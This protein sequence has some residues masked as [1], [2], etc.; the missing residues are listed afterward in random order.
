MYG[1]GPTIVDVQ[2]SA[3][4]ADRDV[5]RMVSGRPDWDPP[6]SL[7][8]GLHEAAE[9]DA[10]SF[11]YAP[12]R[13]LDDLRAA[14]AASLGPGTDP[15]AVTV[16]AGTVEANHLAMAHALERDA[17][18]VA[19]V[20]DPGYPYYAA[21]VRMLGGRV[22]RVPVGSDGSLDVAGLGAA[23][24]DDVALVVVN[25]PNNP[26]GAV[27]DGATLRDAV[28]VA[29]DHDALLVSDEVY[30]RIDRS[31]EFASALSV[32]SDRRVVTGSVSKSLAATGLRVGYAVVPEPLREATT[33]RHVLT[34]IAASRPAQHAVLRAL[35]DVDEPYHRA[36]RECLDRRAATFV[37]ALDGVGAEYVDPVGGM[38]V[39]ARLPGVPGTVSNVHR[40]IAE[41][42]VAAMPGATFGSAYEEWIRF[43]LTTPRVGT[44]ADRVAAFVRSV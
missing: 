5:V 32:D 3:D 28:G 37:D 27:Y 36:V 9:A 30:G 14:L 24:D 13:G 2:E 33:M 39:F 10:G 38:Y 22:R 19:L 20:P 15:E 21:R 34:T 8:E 29:E 42:G 41:A 18:D 16:T 43:S 35:A 23:A 44:A 6:E 40:L 1:Y 12:P 17:G 11:Q 31:G 4:A 7:R 25:T 26:T